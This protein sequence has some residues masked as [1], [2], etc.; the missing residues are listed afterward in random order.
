M[1]YQLEVLK[2]YERFGSKP[3]KQIKKEKYYESDSDESSADSDASSDTG[4]PNYSSPKKVHRS[5]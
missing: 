4:N 3:K 5:R 2:Y 1:Q